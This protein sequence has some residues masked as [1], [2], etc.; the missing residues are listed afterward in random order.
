ML[1][2]ILKEYFMELLFFKNKI[3][4]QNQQDKT[5]KMIYPERLCLEKN[6]CKNGKNRQGY[7]LLNYL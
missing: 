2:P 1:T 4:C 7:G 6:Q 5:D 3:Y